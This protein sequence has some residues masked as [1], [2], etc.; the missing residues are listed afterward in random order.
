MLFNIWNQITQVGKF[1]RSYLL[2]I[3]RLYW[4]YQ[5]L[6]TGF[7][8]LAHL[9]TIAAYFQSLGIPFPLLNATLAGCTEMI[10]GALLI[11]GLFSR[12][13]AIPLMFV[14][15]IAYLTAESD[16]LLILL[17]TLDPTQFFSRTPFLFAYAVVLI[18]CFGPGKISIDYWLTGAHKDK[19]M[20]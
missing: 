12:I 5:F 4:G 2:L 20:P 1:L 14:M 17:R 9:D 6:I 13:A 19:Q 11:L 7:G 16:S 8:K 15:L 18:F 3:I 10:G